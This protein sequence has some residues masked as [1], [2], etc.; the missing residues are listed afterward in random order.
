MTQVLFYELIKDSCTVLK[1]SRAITED[2]K[3]TLA[4]Y[5]GSSFFPAKLKF[6]Y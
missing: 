5:F 1:S 6:S 2:V 4:A 3:P